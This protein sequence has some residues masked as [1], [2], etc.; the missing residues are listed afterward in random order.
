MTQLISYDVEED[1]LD[2]E[3]SKGIYWKSIELQNGMVLDIT[4]DGKV[5]GIEIL[6]AS[7]ALSDGGKVLIEK[8]RVAN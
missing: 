4:K 5:L 2:I 7:Q 6:R 8:A 3:V 1:I